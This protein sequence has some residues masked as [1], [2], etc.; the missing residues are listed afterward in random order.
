MDA[1]RELYGE[2]PILFLKTKPI[3][4]ALEVFYMVLRFKKIKIFLFFYLF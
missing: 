4:D 3:N 1:L 2:K